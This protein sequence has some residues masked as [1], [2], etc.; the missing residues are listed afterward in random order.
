MNKHQ[1]TLLLIKLWLKILCLT[2][3][4]LTEMNKRVAAK[5]Y[6][7]KAFKIYQQLPSNVA[8]TKNMPKLGVKFL[9][10]LYKRMKSP[11]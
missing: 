11:P 10:L 3:G 4:R 5:D 9:N 2:G 1:V 6:L 8:T 7:E